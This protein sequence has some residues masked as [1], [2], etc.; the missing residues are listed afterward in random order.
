MLVVL[1]TDGV[2]VTITGSLKNTALEPGTTVSLRFHFGGVDA[3]EIGTLDI[4]V[5]AGEVEQFQFFQGEF[6]SSEAVTGYTYEV[7]AP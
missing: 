7:I 3:T 6:V 5:Q 2:V 4:Q 1:S